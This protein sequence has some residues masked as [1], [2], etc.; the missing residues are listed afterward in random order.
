LREKNKIL[1]KR[2]GTKKK[3]RTRLK[4]MPKRPRRRRRKIPRKLRNQGSPSP[5]LLHFS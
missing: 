2:A 5:P 4:R 3:L 1:A